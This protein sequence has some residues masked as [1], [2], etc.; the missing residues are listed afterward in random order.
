MSV[1]YVGLVTR[2]IAFAIDAAIVNFVAIVTG[3]VVALVLS[4]LPLTGELHTVLIAVGGVAFVLWVVLYFATFWTGTG[5]TPGNRVMQIRVTRADGAPLRARH[6]LL[7]LVGIVL[8][9]PLLVGFWPILFTQRRRGLHD[10]LA[11]TVVVATLE[12]AEASRS[13]RTARQVTAGG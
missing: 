3:V 8:S 4:L 7:R 6:A 9:C 2:T 12:T 10:K 11:G 5:E 13:V 1:R